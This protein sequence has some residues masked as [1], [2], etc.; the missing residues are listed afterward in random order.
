MEEGFIPSSFWEGATWYTLMKGLGRTHLFHGN[1]ADVT[2][3]RW[4][5]LA[6]HINIVRLHSKWSWE[7]NEALG[8]K[9]RQ[10]QSTQRIFAFW[11]TSA[12]NMCPNVEHQTHIVR[13]YLTATFVATLQHPTMKAFEKL[14]NSCKRK[15]KFIWSKS[16]HIFCL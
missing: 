1:F 7:D 3:G 11:W 15:K 6:M 13:Q 8:A 12:H 14:E 2:R 10:L 9:R 5:L 4:R 16:Q